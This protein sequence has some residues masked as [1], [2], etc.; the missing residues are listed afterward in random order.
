MISV[1]MPCKNH[2]LVEEP[3]VRCA[4]CG[5]AFCP[6]CI[7]EIGGSPYCAVCKGEI[8]GDLR[9]GRPAAGPE[10]AS[11]GRRFGAI[12]LDGLILGLP[13]GAVVL[14]V[15]ASLGLFSGISAGKAPDLGLFW[16]MEGVLFLGAF[17]SW[18]LY[19]GLMLRRSGQ[20]VGKKAMR[21]RVVSAEGSPLSPGQAFGRAA[22]RQ[23]LGIV[24]CLGLV[25]YLTAFGEQRTCIHD[26][27]ARTRVINWNA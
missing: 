24:P 20:T 18:V 7:V 19:E 3:L 2:P 6:N 23:V 25:N 16:A 26:M 12:F 14:G 4:R 8:L 10:L 22:M 17:V 13:L 15:F 1:L 27:V 21:I 5:E 11:I 9:A